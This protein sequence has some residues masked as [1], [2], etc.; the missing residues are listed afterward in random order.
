MNFFREEYTLLFS[1]VS[2][3]WPTSLTHIICLLLADTWDYNNCKQYE[4]TE[5]FKRRR[6]TI[7]QAVMKDFSGYSGGWVGKQE[8]SAEKTIEGLINVKNRLELMAMVVERRKQIWNSKAEIIQLDYNQL[9]WV[10][11]E[12]GWGHD[13][14]RLLGSLHIINQ[15]I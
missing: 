15:E 1:P 7:K 14:L 12:K 3:I 8:P 11:S 6:D 9:W 10:E 13:W 5:S 4:A 2:H